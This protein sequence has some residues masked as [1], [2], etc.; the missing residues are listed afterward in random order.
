MERGNIWWR[1]RT[2]PAE[3][4]QIVIRRL[5]DHFLTSEDLA[6]QL[7]QREL[8]VLRSGRELFLV[9]PFPE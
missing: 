8:M 4:L 1:I 2:C 7:V 9:S 3:D 6:I 5:S